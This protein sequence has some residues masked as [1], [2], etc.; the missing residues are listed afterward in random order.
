M[1]RGKLRIGADERDRMRV[2]VHLA[3]AAAGDGRSVGARSLAVMT[4]RLLRSLS[5]VE[6][7]LA[8]AEARIATLMKVNKAYA[9]AAERHAGERL[10]RQIEVPVS[11]DAARWTGGLSDGHIDRTDSL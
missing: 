3:L 1:R 5:A 7:D 6:M 4:F 11:T 9:R 8:E 2:S 10:E